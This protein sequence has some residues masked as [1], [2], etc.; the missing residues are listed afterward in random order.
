MKT[1]LLFLLLFT[2]NGL[3]GFT[4]VIV[5]YTGGDW[6]NARAGVGVFLTELS[7]R[8]TIDTEKKAVELPLSDTAIFGHPFLFINGHAPLLLNDRERHH[9]R[10]YILAGGFV[11]VNDDYG[12]DESFRK[13]CGEVFPE[14]PLTE[15]PWDHGIYSCFYRFD[16]GLPKIHEHDG[17]AP[18][19]YGLF[20]NGRLALY[21]AFNTDIADGWDPPGTHDDPPQ[22]RES[23][24]R[25]GINI[26][27]WAL[28]E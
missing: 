14:Y 8:T 13:L 17:G 10:Q 24:V 18:K 21:Y 4:F 16:K 28:T 7:A 12:L 15:V 20:I 25:M 6:Y 22:V 27:V 11:F 1:S 2:A 23:A 5:Q 3:F 19:G 26:V 9:L